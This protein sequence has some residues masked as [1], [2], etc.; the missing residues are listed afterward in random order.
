MDDQ[1]IKELAA[2]E[3]G[4]ITDAMYLLGLNQWM[5][6]ILPLKEDYAMCGRAFTIKYTQA[7]CPEA[8]K[9]LGIYDVL[10]QLK[11]NDVIVMQ[12][13]IHD[14]AILGDNLVTIAERRGAAGFVLDAPTRDSANIHKL[15]TPCF[16]AGRHLRVAKEMVITAYQIPIVCGGIIVN[17]GD[18]VI[19]DIDGV[20]VVPQDKAAAALYQAERLDQ[21]EKEMM[22]AILS[23]KSPAECQI[24]IDRK[25]HPRP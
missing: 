6:G 9:P 16:T 21:I 25:K 19:G 14:G 4:V 5:T 22:D 20:M 15:K 12:V 7:A 11:P 10:E 13:G 2:Y 1:I 18:Y 8:I 24:L 3:S 23:D 17:P